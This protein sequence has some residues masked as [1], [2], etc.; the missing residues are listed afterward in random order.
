MM[1]KSSWQFPTSRCSS[2]TELAAVQ[3]SPC[4]RESGRSGQDALSEAGIMPL[5]E[6][7]KVSARKQPKQVVHPFANCCRSTDTHP[8]PLQR[9]NQVGEECESRGIQETFSEYGEEK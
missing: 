8:A 7:H 6:R 2:E 4:H 5:R 3:L 9:E 1:Q